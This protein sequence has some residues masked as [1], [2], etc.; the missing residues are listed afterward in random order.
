MLC[1]RILIRVEDELCFLFAQ[2]GI[3]DGAP[4]AKLREQ[5]VE[6]FDRERVQFG[7]ALSGQHSQCPPPLMIQ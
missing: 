6:C 2:K 7:V 4:L 3:F 1:V 5:V